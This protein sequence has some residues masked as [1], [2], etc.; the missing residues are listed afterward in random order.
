ML[1]LM[2]ALVVFAAGARKINV[3]GIV[4][5]M[6]TNEPADG[7]SIIDASNKKFLCMTRSD[8]RFNIQTDSESE[9]LICFMGTQE[10]QIPVDGRHV[11]EVQLM[12]IPE[13]LNE[14]V[15]TAKSS[16]S[17]LEQSLR[18]LTS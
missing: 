9:L 15:V 18:T 11:M 14:I 3:H 8:G 5:I 2:M 10:L 6:G 7:A 4:T 17:K 12:P 13:T 16:N 1:T